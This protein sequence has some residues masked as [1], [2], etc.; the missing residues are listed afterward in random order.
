MP[1]E[2]AQRK[3]AGNDREDVECSR[4][5]AA[6]VV[7]ADSADV[8]LPRS[9]GIRGRRNS[10]SCRPR[11][12]RQRQEVNLAESVSIGGGGSGG[13]GS[14]NFSG[15]RVRPTAAADQV[16]RT[17]GGRLCRGR[18]PP[19]R[20]GTISGNTGWPGSTRDAQC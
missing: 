20:G 13:G 12:R 18:Y 6:V 17:R 11:Q 5:A 15:V 19:G 8:A 2:K 7:V 1:L 3:R 9:S 4:A 10:N 16:P 14:N